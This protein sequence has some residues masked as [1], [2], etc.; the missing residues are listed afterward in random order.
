MKQKKRNI[1]L[2]HLVRLRVDGETSAGDP[3]VRRGRR[4]ANSSIIKIRAPSNSETR[5]SDNQRNLE[6]RLLLIRRAAATLSALQLK[7]SRPTRARPPP[8]RAN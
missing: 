7:S 2:V 8:A 3:R 1:H 6:Q 4:D 5:Q